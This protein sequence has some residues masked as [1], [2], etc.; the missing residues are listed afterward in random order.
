MRHEGAGAYGPAT[1]RTVRSRIIAD[2]WV[3]DGQVKEEWLTRD[4]AAFARCLGIEP[5]AMAHDMVAADLRRFGEVRFFTPERDRPSAY[6]AK[7]ERGPDVDRCVEAWRSIWDGKELAAIRDHYFHGASV[8]VPGGDALSGH[9]DLD[10]F[11]LSYLASFPDARLG[12][13]SAILNE[14]AGLPVRV[15]LRWW[16][17]GTHAG[18]GRFGEPSGASVHVMGLSHSQMHRGRIIQ[19]WIVIDE[20]AV[21]KQILAYR[22][23]KSGADRR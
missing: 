19:E 10:R 2:C 14:D 18:Y 6:Q 5:L 16:L 3:V 22:E 1:G 20:V 4:Q 9:A 8:L 12:I 23:T 15:A 11:V 7:I 13:E 21:W 17:S